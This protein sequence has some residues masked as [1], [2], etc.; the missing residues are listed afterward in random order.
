MQMKKK[1]FTL[2]EL[3]VVIAIIAILAAMLLPALNQ[4]REKARST[5]CMNNLKQIGTSM[6]LYAQDNNNNWAP[7]HE[8]WGGRKWYDL[9]RKYGQLGKNVNESG[10]LFRCPSEQDLTKVNTYCYNMS[11]KTGMSGDGK[12]LSVLRLRNP[13]R[14]IAIADGSNWWTDRWKTPNGTDG[15][16]TRHSSRANALFFDCHT[17]SLS[18]GEIVTERLWEE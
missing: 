18:S 1:S 9:V 14:L 11:P 6:L 5:T 3:L 16:V 15:L 4:A 10:S 17:A 8:A 7:T 12:S 2:I 13:S